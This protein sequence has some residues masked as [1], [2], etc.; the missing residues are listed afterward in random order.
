[1]Q[2]LNKKFLLVCTTLALIFC[3]LP[4]F[5]FAQAL[6][7]P[8]GTSPELVDPRAIIGNIIRAILGIVGSLALLVFIFGGL[9]WVTSAGSAEKVKK[10]KDM[11]MWAALGLAIIF[12][13]YALVRFVI[14][15]VAGPS[16]ETGPGAQ[17]DTGQGQQ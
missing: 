8:L 1:M 5:V 15:A 11:M 6:E 17:V 4:T 12:F 16:V 2:S 9:T 10:G 14:G 7:N 13:S 3:L